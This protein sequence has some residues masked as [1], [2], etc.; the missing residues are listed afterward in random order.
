MN[1]QNASRLTA[2]SKNCVHGQQHTAVNPY[3]AFPYRCA[4]IEWTAPER[5]AATSLLNGGPT[6]R[7]AGYRALELGCGDGANILPLAYY[8]RDSEFVGVDG[9]V[10]QLEGA[11]RSRARLGLDNLEFIHADFREMH[12]HVGG[13]FEF[14]VAHG[15]CSWIPPEAL[16]SL[17]RFCAAHLAPSGLI[18]VNYNAKP[19]WNIRGMMRDFLLGGTPA[20]ADL[21][22]RTQLAKELA[23]RTAAL[24]AESQNHYSQLLANEL[25]FVCESEP[26]YVAHEF[27]STHNHAYWRSEFLRLADAHGL[28]YVADAD[29]NDPSRHPLLELHTRLVQERIVDSSSE[30]TI[31]LFC[32][33]QLHCPVLTRAP[34]TREAPATTSS[35]WLIASCLAPRAQDRAAY[36]IFV[37]PSGFEV[38]AKEASMARALESLY[39]L[40]PRGVRVSTLFE[41][42]NAVVEDLLALQRNGLVELRLVEPGN[43][44]VNPYVLHALETQANGNS[45]VT[46]AYHTREQP[47]P[48]V[49]SPAELE[50]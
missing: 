24:L 1:S 10:T 49:A 29:F 36:P 18:Y 6:P 39:R 34:F 19:G 42:V 26:S 8:R 33:R 16:Q 11:E 2:R 32:Y 22:T 7:L 43:F 37:H 31:D 50:P 46:S 45:Y 9:A 48:P 41:N 14:I 17:L 12:E 25:R 3:D 15:V 47:R 40:W 28:A 20:D 23:A 35:R 27:L 5:L 21:R 38:E 4:P 13:E 30:D 44:G